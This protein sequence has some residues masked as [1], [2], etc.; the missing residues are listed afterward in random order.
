M[1]TVIKMIDERMKILDAK[2]WHDVEM[3]KRTNDECEDFWREQEQ[4]HIMIW[5]ELRDLQREI[6]DL[7]LI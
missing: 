7:D 1:E 5:T 2:I 6:K 4:M 3:Q